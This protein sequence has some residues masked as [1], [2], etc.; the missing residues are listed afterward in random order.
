MTAADLIVVG[1]GPVGLACA[2]EARL[3][4]IDRKSVV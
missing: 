2:I 1:G 4:G 3:D